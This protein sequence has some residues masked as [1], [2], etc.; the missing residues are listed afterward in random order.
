MSRLKPTRD[1]ST[2]AA[3]SA[4]NDGFLGRARRPSLVPEALCRLSPRFQPGEPQSPW[5][6]PGER[7]HGSRA[8]T[9][10]RPYKWLI[11]DS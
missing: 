7:A 9:P 5:F 4:R 3:A 6:Q 8:T 10:G 1:S 11:A 2:P